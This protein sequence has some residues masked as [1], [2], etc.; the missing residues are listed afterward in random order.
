M[1]RLLSKAYH[2]FYGVRTDNKHIWWRRY[3]HLQER[4]VAATEKKNYRHV[5]RDITG[6]PIQAHPNLCFKKKKS[7]H[8]WQK[9]VDSTL[10]DAVNQ[11]IPLH[12]L[13]FFY[14]CSLQWNNMILSVFNDGFEWSLNFG[15]SPVTLTAKDL[16]HGI[17]IDS[18]EIPRAAWSFLLSQRQDFLS[19][20]LARGPNK[21]Y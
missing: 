4:R 12:S 11:K 19:N 2:S 18:Q 9:R 14:T 15:P 8:T 3:T 5:Q 1:Q 13:L 10:V 21:S 20:H 17:T 7:F 16:V 6:N